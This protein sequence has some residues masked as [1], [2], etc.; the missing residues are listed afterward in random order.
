MNQTATNP[1]MLTADIHPTAIVD[2]S[3]T[4]GAG[5][6]IGAYSIVSGPAVLGDNVELKSH[7][8]VEGITTI[9]DNTVVYPFAVLGAPTPDRKYKGEP[10]RL[11][12]GKRN[13]IRE[14]VTMH[15][16]TA[17]DRMETTVGDDNLFLERSHVAHDCVIGNHVTIVNGVGIA[18][19]VVIEDNVTIGGL[20]GITQRVRIGQGAFIG[21]CCKVEKD[22]LPYALVRGD[23]GYMNGINL[24]G[25]KRRNVSDEDTKTV[26]RAYNQ[27]FGNEGTLSERIAIV[28]AQY[29]DKPL[30]MQMIDFIRAKEKG[31]ITQPRGG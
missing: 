25:L 30:V 9:G 10:S 2:A 13:V 21:G 29:A 24:I 19:H 16:G 23:D 28:A 26:L 20:T 31:G 15:P 27:I 17:D 5:V 22:V 1:A 11:V 8:I 18:G 4:L 7:V 6:R 12:I 14:Y 3:V